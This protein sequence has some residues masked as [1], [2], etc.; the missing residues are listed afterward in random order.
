MSES[1]NEEYVYHINPWFCLLASLAGLI[2]AWIWYHPQL[3]GRL[4][5]LT[6]DQ[7]TKFASQGNLLLNLLGI[8]A[9]F[10]AYAYGLDAII[11]LSHYHPEL[12]V[13]THSAHNFAHGLFHG[14]ITV[15]GLVVFPLLLLNVIFRI[16]KWH[17]LFVHLLFLVV[18]TSLMG[19][20]VDAWH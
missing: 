4:W 14:F 11:E 16:C 2:I 17:H 5:R 20:I 18:C 6:S 7:V 9:L 19:G 10:T 13:A 15:I 8:I 1:M 12:E 3:F